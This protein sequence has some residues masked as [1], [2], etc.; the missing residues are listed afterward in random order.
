LNGFKCIFHRF[1]IGSY[2]IN[3][4]LLADPETRIGVFIDPGGFDESIANMIASHNI[5]LRIIFFTH[6]HWDH[7]D[8]LPEFMKRYSLRCYAGKDE[9]KAANHILQGGRN[10]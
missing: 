5:E 2:P 10:P 4:Y 9:V 1:T 8:G 3:G 6:G 7:V